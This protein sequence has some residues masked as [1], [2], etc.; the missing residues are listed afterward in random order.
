MLP[1]GIGNSN[2]SLG[3]SL[4]GTKRR[5]SGDS[6]TVRTSS[7][8]ANSQRSAGYWEESAQPPLQTRRLFPWSCALLPL[9]DHRLHPH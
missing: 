9:S 2:G 7:R 3:C 6:T 1:G 8:E 4:R 5:G